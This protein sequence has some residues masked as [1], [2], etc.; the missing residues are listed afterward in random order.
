M[1]YNAR[2]K[3]H[4][5]KRFPLM[6]TLGLVLGAAVQPPSTP[7][8]AGGRRCW[9]RCCRIFVAAP[10]VGRRRQERGGVRQLGADATAKIGGGDHRAQLL[11]AAQA[12]GGRANPDLAGPASPA[13]ARL[14]AQ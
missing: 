5:R 10:A 9:S 4:G 13:R 11:S 6:D 1:G 12:L 7:E 2:K 8:R 14:R 3:I